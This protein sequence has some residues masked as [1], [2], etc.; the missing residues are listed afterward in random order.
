MKAELGSM[1]QKSGEFRYHDSTA[2]L[3]SLLHNCE[4]C[5]RIYCRYLFERNL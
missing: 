4:G 1:T 5:F 2:I 3:G